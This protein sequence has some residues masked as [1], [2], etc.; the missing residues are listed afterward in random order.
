MARAR[1]LKRRVPLTFSC[2]LPFILAGRQSAEAHKKVDISCAIKLMVQS[3][4]NLTKKVLKNSEKKLE[5]ASQPTSSIYKI[6]R[7]NSS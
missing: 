7:S 3:P 6:L 1:L 4:C 2:L 5:C